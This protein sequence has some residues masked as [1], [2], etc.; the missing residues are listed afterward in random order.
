MCTYF[1]AGNTWIQS[2]SLVPIVA[3]NISRAEEQIQDSSNIY[4]L[5]FLNLAPEGIS[6]HLELILQGKLQSGLVY[7]NT[8]A[9]ATH[10]SSLKSSIHINTIQVPVQYSAGW[11]TQRNIT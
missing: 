7:G 11:G 5:W 6:R 3:G 9:G 2:S 1:K 10:T 8:P 4:K